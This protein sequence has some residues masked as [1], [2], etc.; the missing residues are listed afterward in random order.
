ML[1]L[2]SQTQQPAKP[3]SSFPSTA[4][5]VLLPHLVLKVSSERQTNCF[6]TETWAASKGGNHR[7]PWHF[8]GYRT[9]HSN[10]CFIS[11]FLSSQLLGGCTTN[12]RAVRMKGRRASFQERWPS[13]QVP[14]ILLSNT[15]PSL[16]PTFQHLQ[17]SHL[18]WQ[19]PLSG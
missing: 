12:R 18:M 16:H 4:C 14:V 7:D 9:F 8:C 11:L 15:D 1:C 19:A 17:P 6:L 13:K 3:C 2:Y 5:T 10:M